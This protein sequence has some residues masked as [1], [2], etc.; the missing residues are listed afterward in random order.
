MQTR[1]QEWH[2]D[3]LTW[4]PDKYDG[5]KQIV[6]APTEVWLPDLGI[7]NRSTSSLLE[8]V[9]FSFLFLVIHIRVAS[10]G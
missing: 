1:A 2:D 9:H 8:L 5:V 7:Q 3:Y 6:L 10:V 4:A